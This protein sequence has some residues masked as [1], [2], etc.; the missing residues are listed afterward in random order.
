MKRHIPIRA[1][2]AACAAASLV[3]AL[4]AESQSIQPGA[5]CFPQLPG[6]PECVQFFEF[7]CTA[8]DGIY[9]GDGTTCANVDC[10]PCPP[11]PC[12]EDINGDGSIDSDDL[13]LLLAKFGE[14]CTPN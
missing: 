10:S 4:P 9:Q 8:L 1:A 3:I 13:N 14:T 7:D 12:P 6:M 2:V 11:N 5:C